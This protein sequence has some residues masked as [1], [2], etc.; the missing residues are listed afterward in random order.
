L[1]PCQATAFSRAFSQVPITTPSHASILSGTYPQFNHVTPS[2]P[3]AE[4]PICPTRTR[5]IPD[6]S[7]RRLFVLD[8]RSV[9]LGFDRG[10]DTY[11]AGLRLLTPGG[12][13]YETTERRAE[14]VIAHTLAWFDHRS[15]S[16]PFF[17]WVHL[18]D[19]HDPY[20]PPEP[21]KSKFSDP[22]DGEIAY[23]DAML[24]KLFAALRMAGVYDGT[25][26]RHG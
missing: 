15:R 16:S 23:A 20:D 5:M 18:Y 1:T 7:F 4:V 10:F 8:P 2:E 13:R 12:N 21:Y 17:M 24:G 11:D 9:A 22:Y 19:P 26:R 6:C 14:E 3:P 25:D